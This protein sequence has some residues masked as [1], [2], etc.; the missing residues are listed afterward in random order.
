MANAQKTTQNTHHL[1]LNH[2]GFQ[3]W[4]QQDLLILHPI[5]T[6]DNYAD[7]MTKALGR[8][9]FYWY[10]NFIMGRIVPA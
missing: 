7:A 1:D 5:N 2:F 9:L 3:K 10:M 4:V 6:S 8:T